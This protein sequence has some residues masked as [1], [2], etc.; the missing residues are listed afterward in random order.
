M[1]FLKNMVAKVSEKVQILR[2][3]TMSRGEFEDYCIQAEKVLEESLRMYDFTREGGTA[4]R[5]TASASRT[6]THSLF[7]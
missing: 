6:L 1:S 4:R 7:C 2:E 5:Q 3:G